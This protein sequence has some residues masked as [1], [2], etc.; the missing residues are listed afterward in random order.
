MGESTVG[1]S[2]E[3]VCPS[4][5]NQICTNLLN[6]PTLYITYYKKCI[7]FHIHRPF[8]SCMIIVVQGNEILPMKI[9]KVSSNKEV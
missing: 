4:V 9:A 2:A 8:D 7:Q 5:S 6:V 1:S 3:P